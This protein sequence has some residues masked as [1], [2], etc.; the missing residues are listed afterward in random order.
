[1]ADTLDKLDPHELRAAA[2]GVVGVLLNLAAQ[3][4]GL[5]R[6]RATPDA[7][8]NM[9]AEAGMEESLHLQ[10]WWPADM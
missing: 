9:L 8:R 1:M 3:P 5:P 4:E 2:T 6:T 10:G 7:V